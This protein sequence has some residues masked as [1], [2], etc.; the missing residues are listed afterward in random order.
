[1]TDDSGIAAMRHP[2]I[3]LRLMLGT[4]IVVVAVLIVANIAIYRAFERT[5]WRE[6]DH[7][8]SQSAS[9]LSNSVEL[10][11]DS[12]DYGWEEALKKPDVSDITGIFQFWDLRSGETKKSPE[13]KANELPSFHGRLNQPVYRDI[14]F[15]NGR[16]ARAIGLLHLPFLDQET[17]EKA[18][19]QGSIPKR[20]DHPQVLVC[21]RETE[22]LERR[23]DRLKGHLIRAAGGTLVAIWGSIYLISI[24]C[25]R[26]LRKFNDNL[27]EHAEFE[28]P[29]PLEI[30]A[31]LPSEIIGIAHTVNIA[32][33]RIERSRAR[34]KEFA[35]NA[36]HELRTPLA[37]ILATLEQAVHR[38]RPAEELTGRI[39]DAIGISVG[40]RS[41][42]GS[43]MQMARL[44][45][46]LESSVPTRVDPVETVARLV[47]SRSEKAAFRRLNV[48]LETP[49]ETRLI[50]VDVGLFNVLLSNLIDNALSHSPEG[51]AVGFH[52]MESPDNFVFISRNHSPDLTPEMLDDLFEPFKRGHSSMDD[53]K[54]HAG[55]GLSLSRE[56]ARILGG[57]VKAS[58]DCDGIV[59][60]TATIPYV[61]R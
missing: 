2:S 38:P 7:Q 5:L 6:V 3:R 47:G 28:N 17:S 14:T 44:R 61:K 55:L 58:I 39:H 24:W 50:D 13:L 54:G 46:G 42:L 23:L 36:A 20:E 34:E 27:L 18:G 32:L 22:T 43:L 29:P 16:H 15:R 19:L 31:K 12:L 11:S 59:A 9:L 41:T 45:G 1:M 57:K 25:L 48:H 60:F 33:D 8:L 51:G 56:A 35:L 4:G 10:E 52:V 49:D 40:M 37:G 21:A 30:P 26:P 53:P